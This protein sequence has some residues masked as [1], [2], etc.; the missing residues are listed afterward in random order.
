MITSSSGSRGRSRGRGGGGRARDGPLT[1]Q[2]VGGVGLPRAVHSAKVQRCHCGSPKCK[3][4]IGDVAK[5]ADGN[6]IVAGTARAA[7]LVPEE[8]VD[9]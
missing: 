4:Y 3:G 1:P 5:D 2:C 9:G 8:A 6:P 7:A